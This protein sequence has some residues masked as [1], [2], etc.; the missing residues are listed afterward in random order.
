[1]IGGCYSTFGGLLPLEGAREICGNPRTITAGAFRP[2][3]IAQ[4]G[5]GGYLVSGRWQLGS[6]CCR[7]PIGCRALG[8]RGVH[9]AGDRENSD[10]IIVPPG[11]QAGSARYLGASGLL[12]FLARGHHATPAHFAMTPPIAEADLNTLGRYL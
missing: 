11:R 9:A 10:G 3:G 12:T 4:R 1:M 2:A 6:G 5:D 7:R 8:S